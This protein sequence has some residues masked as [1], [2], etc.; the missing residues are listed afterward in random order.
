MAP[1][2]YNYAIHN[3]EL[4]VIIRAFEQW[5]AEIEGMAIPLKVYSD[6]K[7]LEFFITKQNLSA[8]QAR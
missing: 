2:E 7:A 5:R 6:H 1:T 3:K 8:R 4:L